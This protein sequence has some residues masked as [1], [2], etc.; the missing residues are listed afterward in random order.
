MI[1][2]TEY[3]MQELLKAYQNKA[4]VKLKNKI[5]AVY[6]RL[7]GWVVDDVIEELK[8]SRSTINKWVKEYT[9]GGLDR[10][11]TIKKKDSTKLPSGEKLLEVKSMV[12][13]SQSNARP[14]RGS[15]LKKN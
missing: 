15:D 6:Y 10:I 13:R 14:D 2:E 12:L 4:N 7:D 11:L 8:I 9:L 3:N 5:L 1:H